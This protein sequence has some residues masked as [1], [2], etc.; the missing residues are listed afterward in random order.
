MGSIGEMRILKIYF[1]LLDPPR[2]S[3]SLSGKLGFWCW[4]LHLT[5][6]VVGFLAPKLGTGI[7]RCWWLIPYVAV[8]PSNLL[9]DYPAFDSL[10][11]KFNVAY[12][13]V[14][15]L[16]GGWDYTK[17]ELVLLYYWESIV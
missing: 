1:C 11:L 9:P 17:I 5:S 15:G 12:P 16:L 3:W 2:C 6:S 10:P 8:H 13:V 7:F 4:N 14:D